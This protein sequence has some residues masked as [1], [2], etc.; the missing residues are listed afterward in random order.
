MKVLRMIWS[1]EG[2]SVSGL[3]GIINTTRLL[4]GEGK[5]SGFQDIGG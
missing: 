3:R 5:E 2:I 4:T 1:E